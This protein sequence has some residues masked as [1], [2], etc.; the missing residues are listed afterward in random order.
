MADPAATTTLNHIY[1]Q[2][3]YLTATKYVTIFTSSGLLALIV[4]QLIAAISGQLSVGI[5]VLAFIGILVGYTTADFVTG[6]THWFC[7][8][9]FSEDTPIIGKVLIEPFRDHHSNPQKITRYRFVEQDTSSFFILAPILLFN[10]KS[11]PP[12]GHAQI[13]WAAFLVGI[14]LG[15]FGTNFFHRWAHQKQVARPV[16]WLQKYGLI[17]APRQHAL[18]HRSYDAGYCVTSGWLNPALDAI[19]FYSI[20]ERLIRR[21]GPKQKTESKDV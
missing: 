16:R 5:L 12:N 19:Q 4:I 11:P 17:L 15:L 6:T 10:L 9:F 20:L 13:Y 2:N 7:D 3:K 1:P 8:T 18:H 14:C 21:I